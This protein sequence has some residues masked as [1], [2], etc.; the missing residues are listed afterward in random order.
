MPHFQLGDLQVTLTDHVA[1][2]EIC[3]PPH[4]YF[5]ATLIGDIATALEQLDADPACRA[6]VLCAQGK[7][8]CA[9]ADFS[10]SGIY[11]QQEGT[12]R[13]YANAVRI[14]AVRKPLIA[15]IQGP[16]IGGGLGLALAADFRI[17]CPEA[18]FSANFVKLGTHAGFGITHTLP[19]LVGQQ[20][21]SLMLLTGRRI[22]GALALEWGLV[23]TLVEQS[24]IRN[25]ARTLALEIAANAPLAVVATRETLRTGLAETVRA[26][27][28]L[29]D[30]KQTALFGT[31][32]HKE[33]VLAVAQRR[34]GNFS[35]R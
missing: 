28:R 30:A 12:T 9:G 25:T 14:F 1:Q 24:E 16:A 20:R 22:A 8:F 6:T 2:V 31:E 35:G 17:A 19:A 4:N 15:A 13:L 11:S 3:R 18:R 21:A 10:N 5:D 27:T 23:D 32:D 7:S 33:G 26:Q 29:E 34:P